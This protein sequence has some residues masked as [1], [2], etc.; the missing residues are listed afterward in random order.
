MTRGNPIIRPV[1]LRTI[2]EFEV[3]STGTVDRCLMETP[4]GD[5]VEHYEGASFVDVNGRIACR[6]AIGPITEQLLGSWTVIGKFS[7]NGR[8]TEIHQTTNIIQEG[9]SHHS[10]IK[11]THYIEL[12]L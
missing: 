6:L 9:R 4:S 1:N 5:V 11:G 7:L 12:S 8:F 10:H 2:P 3:T